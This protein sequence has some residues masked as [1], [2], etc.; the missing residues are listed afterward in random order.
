MSSL[1]VD[2]VGVF[3]GNITSMI[4]ARLVQELAPPLA[5]ISYCEET[6]REQ[7]FLKIPWN[8]ETVLNFG[9]AAR[10]LNVFVEN[11]DIPPALPLLQRLR[12]TDTASGDM[13]TMSVLVSIHPGMCRVQARVAPD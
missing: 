12:R 9:F 13:H 8:Y 6:R 4:W 11:T 10:S 5:E 7:K 1:W 2:M 3:G